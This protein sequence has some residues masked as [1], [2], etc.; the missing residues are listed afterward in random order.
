MNALRHLRCRLAD[1]PAAGWVAGL[2]SWCLVNYAQV[3]PCVGLGSDAS[4]YLT[5]TSSRRDALA[6]Y[7]GWFSSVRQA[8]SMAAQPR[9]S[10][11]G[12]IQSPN[13]RGGKFNVRKTS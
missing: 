1:D 13:S 12:G 9:P 4:P 6:R 5:V 2:A 10:F 3:L 11:G 8:D 7:R